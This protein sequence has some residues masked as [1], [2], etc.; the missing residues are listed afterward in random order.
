MVDKIKNELTKNVPSYDM[1]LNLKYLITIIWFEIYI[2]KLFTLNT[3][4]FSK[5]RI[6]TCCIFKSDKN[7]LFYRSQ[8]RNLFE[9][10][11]R[12]YFGSKNQ[13]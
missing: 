10:T 11:S 9:L 8:N 12:Y 5:G 2:L 6:Q 13:C 7:F 1:Y 4:S 3:K